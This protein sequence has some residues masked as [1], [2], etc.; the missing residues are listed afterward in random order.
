MILTDLFFVWFG[1]LHT[2]TI[3]GKVG[4]FSQNF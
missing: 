3:T 4:E 2:V 1:Y